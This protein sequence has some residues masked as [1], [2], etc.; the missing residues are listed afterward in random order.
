MATKFTKYENH[1]LTSVEEIVDLTFL[2]RIDEREFE[3]P[4]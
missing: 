3:K 1:K 4:Q 2:D